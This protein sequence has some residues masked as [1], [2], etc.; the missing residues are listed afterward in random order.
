M[1]AGGT[2]DLPSLLSGLFWHMSVVGSNLVDCIL[3]DAFPLPLY[4]LTDGPSCNCG[5]NNGRNGLISQ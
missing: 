3:P 4:T 5:L 2:D 1:A